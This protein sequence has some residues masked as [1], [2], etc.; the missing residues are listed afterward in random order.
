[1]KNLQSGSITLLFTLICLVSA[2]QNSPVNEPVDKP[3]LFQ[4]LPERL[5][6]QT[7]A[8]ESFLNKPIGQ[9]A[10][11]QLGNQFVLQGQIVSAANKFNNSVQS[12]V[13]RSSNREG[14]CFSFTK[15]VNQDGT[16]IWKGRIISMMHGDGYEIVNENGQYY[17]QKRDFYEMMN[18]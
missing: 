18:E 5:P 1:M 15:V 4:D 16:I 11:I 2:A 17:L 14:A 13:I 6:V 9:G 10:A 8:L 7:S 3:K 12:S